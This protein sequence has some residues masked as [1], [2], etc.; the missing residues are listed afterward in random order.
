MRARGRAPASWRCLRGGPPAPKGRLGSLLC[1]D[2]GG[3]QISQLALVPV[4]LVAVLEQR[5]AVSTRRSSRAFTRSASWECSLSGDG[6]AMA[7]PSDD[8]LSP[9]GTSP[10]GRSGAQWGW[11]RYVPGL[12]RLVRWRSSS[13]PSAAAATSATARRALAMSP[14]LMLV[15]MLGVTSIAA[16]PSCHWGCCD[17]RTNSCATS[18]R[19][20]RACQG[21][22]GPRLLRGVRWQWRRTLR[23]NSHGRHGLQRAGHSVSVRETRLSMRYGGQR[24][25]TAATKRPASAGAATTR[26]HCGRAGGAMRDWGGH[27]GLTRPP[28]CHLCPDSGRPVDVGHEVE[29]GLDRSCRSSRRRA[30]G[31]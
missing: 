31:T 9:L 18:V 15:S 24:A 1:L 30:R 20:M 16:S 6:S 13:S 5:G 10:H 22:H 17:S 25:S 23:P 11:R 26:A 2:V 29:V 27:A 7:A 3:A 28:L 12:M 19:T 14:R 4:E 8:R 21:H